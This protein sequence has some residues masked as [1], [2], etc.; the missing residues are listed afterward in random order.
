MVAEMVAEM[1]ADYYHYYH[2]YLSLVR[3]IHYTAALCSVCIS[4]S[5]SSSCRR[6]EYEDAIK[7]CYKGTGPCSRPSFYELYYPGLVPGGMMK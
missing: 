1:V 5:V 6:E 7:V 2:Y 4:T 3:L